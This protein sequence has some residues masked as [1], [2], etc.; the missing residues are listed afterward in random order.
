MLNWASFK[1]KLMLLFVFMSF[2]SAL[3]GQKGNNEGTTQDYPFIEKTENNHALSVQLRLGQLA[4]KEE[5]KLTKLHLP[6]TSNTF[7]G[8]RAGEST[9]INIV[10]NKVA[11]GNNT[12]FG[13]LSGSANTQAKDNTYFGAG[14]GKS[15]FNFSSNTL[16]GAAAGTVPAE[17]QNV[18]IGAGSGAGLKT[19]G[20]NTLVGFGSGAFIPFTK[21]SIHLGYLAGYASGK[22]GQNNIYI[23]SRTGPTGIGGNNNL[24]IGGGLGKNKKGRKNLLLIGN[25]NLANPL[26]QGFF[27]KMKVLINAKNV[28]KVVHGDNPA[29]AGFLL[30]NNLFYQKFYVEKNGLFSWNTYKKN[31]TDKENKLDNILVDTNGNFLNTLAA[32]NEVVQS[33]E[34][35]DWMTLVDDLLLVQDTNQQKKILTKQNVYANLVQEKNGQMYLNTNGTTSLLIGAIQQVQE[36]LEITTKNISDLKKQ[37]E[38]LKKKVQSLTKNN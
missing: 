24:F 35:V 37:T 4:I 2:C 27:E 15:K 34:K 8:N 9:K 3:L 26:I 30:N 7:F 22:K 32:T 18:H 23:G 12:Y 33:N 1:Y 17:I 21:N 5:H 16:L 14:L 38:I 36:E 25:H 31:G 6:N 19:G 28:M 20:N 10:G 29:D 13:H 11:K